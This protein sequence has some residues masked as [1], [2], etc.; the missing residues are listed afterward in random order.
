MKKHTLRRYLASL[1]AVL[2]LISVAG[3]SPAVFADDTTP[4]S[5]GRNFRS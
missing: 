4:P 3:V 1:L 5:A 2:M